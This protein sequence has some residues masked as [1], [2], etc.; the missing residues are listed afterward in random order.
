[1]NFICSTLSCLQMYLGSGYIVT[2]TPNQIVY[3]NFQGFY[4]CNQSSNTYKCSKKYPINN[5]SN[6]GLPPDKN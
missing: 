5:G 4:I 3:Y 6:Q 1:M 2:E